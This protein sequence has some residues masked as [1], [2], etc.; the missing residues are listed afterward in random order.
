LDTEVVV[1]KTFVLFTVTDIL[2]INLQRPSPEFN[3]LPISKV[4]GN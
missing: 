4:C 3:T 1:K 2:W